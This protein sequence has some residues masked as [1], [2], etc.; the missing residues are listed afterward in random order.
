MSGS[1]TS[2]PDNPIITELFTDRRFAM[3]S[4][5]VEVVRVEITPHPNADRLELAN[6]GGYHVV[7]GKGTYETGDLAAYI[8]E[9]ALVPEEILTE[10]GLRGKLD[11]PQR[12]RVKVQR[13]RG[14]PSQ[15]LC[16][17]DKPG[18]AEG[19]SVT[20][21]LGIT[22]Y[23]P[24]VPVHMDGQ[25]YAAGPERT[26]RYDIENF[27]RYPD[28][29]QEGEG[30]VIAEKLHG[31]F[32]CLGILS[33]EDAHPEYGRIAVTSKG[34]GA[35]GLVFKP[36][37]PENENNLYLRV[38]KQV[39][40]ENNLLDARHTFFLL[41]EVYGSGVQ[42]LTYGSRDPG[43]RVFDLVITDS[44]GQQTFADDSYLTAFL[45]DFP[46]LERV[47]V[48]YRGPFSKEVLR[49]LTD[50][51]ETVSGEASHIREGVVVRPLEERRDPRLGRVQLKSIS[52][53]YLTRRG[54][55]EYT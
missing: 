50:G 1:V 15:G 46:N 19:Q 4:F 43:F 18:W 3:A 31:T 7:V 10:M 53:D 26:V 40:A 20:E 34:L 33:E 39:I 48:L 54:G 52:A 14:I 13:L 37:V 27:K 36:D 9:A 51:K 45:E 55:T 25:I 22:K 2:C 28:V 6:V 41:G 38:A 11:G 12:N 16:Y 30:V 49:E 35:R 23:E 44:E 47:P 32:M 5:K 8:P 21:E 29:L 24:P 17:P 42:D